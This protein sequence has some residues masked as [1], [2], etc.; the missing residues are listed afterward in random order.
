MRGGSYLGVFQA[1]LGR[2]LLAVGLADV[3]LLLEHLLQRL[4]LHVREHGSAQHA[5]AGLSARG[6]RPGEGPGDGHDAGGRCGG[7]GGGRGVE[8]GAKE[9]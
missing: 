2:Q 1:Q 8:R 9:G 4:A 7:G 6:Q 3:L 5:P